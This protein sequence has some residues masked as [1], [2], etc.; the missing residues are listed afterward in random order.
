M[1]E[2]DTAAAGFSLVEVIIAMLILGVIAIALLPMLWQGILLSSQQS[3]SATATRHLNSLIEEARETPTCA[4][5]GSITAAVTIPDGKGA[6]LD[7]VGAYDVPGCLRGAAVPVTLTATDASG[8]QL[9]RV[10]ARVYIP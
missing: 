3:A 4:T 7:I 2:H 8:T 10:D 5:L 6:D 1:R 9:A